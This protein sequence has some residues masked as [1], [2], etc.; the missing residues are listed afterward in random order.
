[1]AIISLIIFFIVGL[2]LL[3]RIDVKRAMAEADQDPAGVV[4]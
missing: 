4:I 1:V 2:A 3:S